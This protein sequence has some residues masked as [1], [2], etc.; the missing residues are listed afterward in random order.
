MCFLYTKYVPRQFQ[1]QNVQ[2]YHYIKV[3]PNCWGFASVKLKHLAEFKILHRSGIIHII[4][5]A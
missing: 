5:L 2:Q 3:N 1:L 4:D